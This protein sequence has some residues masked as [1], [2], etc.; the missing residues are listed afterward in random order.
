MLR[1]LLIHVRP[2]IVPE[3]T[4]RE[5]E[6][7]VVLNERH[8][9]VVGGHEVCAA[10]LGDQDR[11]AGIPQAR[12]LVP[13]PSTDETVQETRGKCIAGAQDIF[14][15]HRKAWHLDLRGRTP[16]GYDTNHHAYRAALL[17]EHTRPQAKQRLDCS[18]D[19]TADSCVRDLG[20]RQADL[21][22]IG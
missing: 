7:T 6:S 15:L 2:P 5:L 10:M 14:H 3:T 1:C 18:I 9:L 21:A 11:A 17:C 8:H 22:R 13:V 12:S 16:V 4:S 19:V 20:M